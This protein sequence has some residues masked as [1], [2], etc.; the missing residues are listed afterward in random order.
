MRLAL[1]LLVGFVGSA[2]AKPWVWQ[3]SGKYNHDLA[4]AAD[5]S[6][7]YFGGDTLRLFGADGKLRKEVPGLGHVTAITYAPD[8]D[9][10]V[11]GHDTKSGFVT[12][13]KPDGTRRWAKQ[14]A[15]DS[16]YTHGVAATADRV[17]VVGRF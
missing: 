12:R 10:V 4:A 14:I 9:L 2:A 11:V 13:L 6:V 16:T 1:L 7:A 8:G 15:V 5:G 17:L 3:K